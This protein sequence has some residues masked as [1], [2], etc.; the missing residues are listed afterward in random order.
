MNNKSSI[1]IDHHFGV[2]DCMGIFFAP[3]DPN[4][5]TTNK[6]NTQ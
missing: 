3:I 1:R 5:L 6:G 2:P 4:I